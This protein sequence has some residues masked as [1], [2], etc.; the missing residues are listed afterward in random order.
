MRALLTAGSRCSRASPVKDP[1]ARLM[2]NWM[3]SSNTCVHADNSSTTIPNTAIRQMMRLAS[4]AYPYPAHKELIQRLY[5]H[6]NSIVLVLLSSPQGLVHT[7]LQ[8]QLWV[9]QAESG[10]LREN[11][12]LLFQF[13]SLNV[14]FFSFFLL[15]KQYCIYK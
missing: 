6:N 15:C 14:F 8:K 11:A 10:L 5:T 9:I 13:T 7:E 4:V 3:Q 2:Q 12:F 1:T